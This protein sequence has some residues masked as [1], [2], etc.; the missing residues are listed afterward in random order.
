MLDLYRPAKKQKSLVD[1][2]PQVVGQGV[3]VDVLHEGEPPQGEREE[4]EQHQAEGEVE[5]VQQREIDGE[6][7]GD[8]D[9]VCH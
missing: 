4:D 7:D 8:E 9:E 5:E 3:E 6:V 2:F 1:E